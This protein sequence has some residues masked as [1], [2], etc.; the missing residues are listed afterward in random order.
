MYDQLTQYTKGELLSDIQ[1][2]GPKQSMDSYRKAFAYGR[3]KTAEN[4]HRARNRVTRP[5]IAEN[6]EDLE[7]RYKKWKK[8]IAYLKD[9][10]AYDLGEASVVS[11]LLDLVPD[12]V[13]K[14]I[15]AKHKT[16][17]EKASSLKQ[18]MLEFDKIITREK[19]RKQSKAD[20]KPDNLKADNS[21]KKLAYVG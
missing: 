14:E 21:K 7:D 18:I 8:D 19:G 3:K 6:M 1:M 15:S 5:E 10:D 9:I 17:G 4:V 13:H 2:A 11:I 16:F 12:E 20:R